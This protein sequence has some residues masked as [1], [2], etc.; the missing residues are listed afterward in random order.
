MMYSSIAIYK[1]VLFTS[2]SLDAKGKHRSEWDPQ[3]H[4][5]YLLKNYNLVYSAWEIRYFRDS[6][7]ITD[8]LVVS[9]Y[10]CLV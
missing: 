9:T 7:R 4:S 10:S 8:I 5:R 6:V 3:P 2:A 1:Y